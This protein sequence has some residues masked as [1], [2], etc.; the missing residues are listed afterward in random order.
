MTTVAA[1]TRAPRLVEHDRTRHSPPGG[2]DAPTFLEMLA[3]AIRE[4]RRTGAIDHYPSKLLIEF[5][6]LSA[7]VV[8][9]DRH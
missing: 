5:D 4:A 7:T 8:P 3:F 9:D 1:G 2:W 6:L